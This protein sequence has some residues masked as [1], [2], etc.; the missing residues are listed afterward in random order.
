[1]STLTARR[2]P[3]FYWGL[4]RWDQWLQERFSPAHV[5]AADPG[6]FSDIECRWQITF[7][8]GTRSLIRI[9]HELID[10]DPEDFR[11]LIAGLEGYGWVEAL[12]LAGPGGLRLSSLGDN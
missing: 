11:R 7:P 8:S 12:R 4:K 9:P 6:V 1:M 3:T 2:S 5:A 10:A